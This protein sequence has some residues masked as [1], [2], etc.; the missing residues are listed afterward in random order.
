MGRQKLGL[1]VVH[2]RRRDHDIG[3]DGALI[4]AHARDLPVG[5]LD[6]GHLLAQAEGGAKLLSLPVYGLDHGREATLRVAHA[7][8]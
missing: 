4:R 2:V 1:G 3:V 7:L 8:H 5:D 6:G